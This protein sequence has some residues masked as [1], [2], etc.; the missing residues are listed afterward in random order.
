MTKGRKPPN[1]LPKSKAKNLIPSA[2]LK[3]VRVLPD[4]MPLLFADGLTVQ[5]RDAMFLVS[6]LQT[7]YPLAVTPE[8]IR[9]IK[10]IEQHCVA[11]IIIT[12]DQMA[13]N[14]NALNKNF[15]SFIEAQEPE[16]QKHLR[17]LLNG[18]ENADQTKENE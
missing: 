5:Q 3:L 16:N 2:S 13:R 17:S 1:M 9:A 7:K 14:L 8:E 10:T 12:P 18:E 6:F 11:Q 15:N 4:N